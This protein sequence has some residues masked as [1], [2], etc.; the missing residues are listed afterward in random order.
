MLAMLFHQLLLDGAHRTPDKPALHWVE[1]DRTLT[2]ARAV[3]QMEQVAAAL[4]G[5]G[6]G[7]GD[8][9]G[10]FAHNGLDYLMAMF[11]AWRA[12]AISTHINLQYADTLDYYVNDATPKVLIYTGDHLAAVERHRPNLTSVEHYVCMDGPQDGAIG[13]AEWVAAA[14][15]APPDQVQETDIAHLSYTSGTSGH[16]KGACLAHEPTSRA[17]RCIAERLR[18]TAADVSLGPTALSSSYQLVANLLPPLHVGG[19]VC[20]TSRWEAAQGWDAAET[21]GASIVAA[22]PVV[23]RDVLEESMARGRP[24]HR[25]RLG[26]SGGGPVPPE[27]KLAWRDILELPLCESY[28]QSELGGFVGLWAPDHPIIEERVLS[29]GRALP[30]KE[31]RA[32]DD[33]GREV[34][35][36]QL[37]ELCL[38]G[39]FMTGY[40][41]RPEK[42]AEALRD[43]WLHTGDVGYVDAEGFVFMRGRV[44]ERLTIDGA[45][46]YPRDV[47]E[48]LMRHPAVREAAL[49]GVPD[50]E[51][52]QR[53]IA[54]VTAR[55][56]HI[57]DTMALVQ[58]VA[59][60]LGRA[61]PGMTVEVIEAMPMTPTGK[62]SKAQLLAALLAPTPPAEAARH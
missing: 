54:Y 14:G 38:R 29:C 61:V 52:G 7:R 60:G 46:W 27:L 8:R 48:V 24:P 6:V 59:D 58:F 25:L 36:G 11:G 18:M 33:D 10:I 39:G 4:A 47:E 57:P 22:N 16:P 45:H 32:L 26:I 19:T 41:N 20:V 51:R 35:T 55:D 30:D 1:R 53:P 49:I 13:W 15:S 34:A 21:L 2:Y 42:T 31:V 44:S 5:L 12:G 9:V 28:G 50:E 62:I 23:L 3:E 17:T 40:W 56:G 43:G 37:A